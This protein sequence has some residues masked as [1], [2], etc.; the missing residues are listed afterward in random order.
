MPHTLLLI[1]LWLTVVLVS[2][3]QMEEFKDWFSRVREFFRHRRRL[4]SML[5]TFQ[6]LYEK[7]PTDFHRGYYY[8]KI[9]M[10]ETELEEM[11]K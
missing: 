2:K 8:G 7:S 3:P 10:I 4:K 6:M 5:T 11:W 9:R 1:C